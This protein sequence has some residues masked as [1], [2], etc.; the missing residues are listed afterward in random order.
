MDPP[1]F[2]APA[3]ERQGS[4]FSHACW[5]KLYDSSATQGIL[6]RLLWSN[7]AAV[8]CTFEESSEQSMGAEKEGTCPNCKAIQ[9]QEESTSHNMFWPKGRGDRETYNFFFFRSNWW[10][11]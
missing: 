4:M 2:D 3:E 1:H 7:V 9:L 11:S 10:N 6:N 8:F 5:N